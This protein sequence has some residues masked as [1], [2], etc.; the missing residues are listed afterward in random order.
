MEKRDVGI[1][2]KFSVR[3]TDGTDNPGGKHENCR[4]F[5]LDLDHDKFSIPA[6]LAYAEACSIEYPVLSVDL[7]A[8]ANARQNKVDETELK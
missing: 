8:F 5:V 1:Y 6:I 4:Y 7:L 3:R 2:E